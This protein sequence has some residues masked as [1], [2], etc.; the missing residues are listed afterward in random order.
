MFNSKI[1][2]DIQQK[3]LD[4]DYMLKH[5][6]FFAPVIPRYI[7]AMINLFPN[8]SE[9]SIR[10]IFKTKI[11]IREGL[12]NGFAVDGAEVSHLPNIYDLDNEWFSVS[13]Y[14]TP[15]EYNLDDYFELKQN[16]QV[17]NVPISK[18]YFKKDEYAPLIYPDENLE[19]ISEEDRKMQETIAYNR[20]R[21]FIHEMNHVSSFKY[22]FFA[23]GRWLANRWQG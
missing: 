2:M 1:P 15:N 23:K 10:N 12:T 8:C 3:L 17:H 6:K 11:K 21:T 22:N 4:E 9:Q 14:T 13:I 18:K 20:Y 7:E 16:S 19:G 5:F